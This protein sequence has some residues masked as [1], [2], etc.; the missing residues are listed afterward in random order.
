VKELTKFLQEFVEQY[1]KSCGPFVW[2][3]GPKKL[4]RIIELTKAYQ[5]DLHT[6]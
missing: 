3:K 5:A 2:T 6:N 4:K 1:N